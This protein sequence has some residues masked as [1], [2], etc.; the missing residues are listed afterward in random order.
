MAEELLGQAANNP[1][2]RR[3]RR[4]A[5]PGGLRSV[6]SSNADGGLLPL[7][8]WPV[9]SPATGC[10]DCSLDNSRT[11]AV[12]ASYSGTRASQPP[13]L[14]SARRMR[15][16]TPSDWPSSSP[17]D[18]W[19]AA[20]P[21]PPLAP[22]KG[23]LVYELDASAIRFLP[24]LGEET[25]KA[26]SPCWPPC[27]GARSPCVP[28]MPVIGVAPCQW[29]CRRPLAGSSGAMAAMTAG[30]SVCSSSLLRTQWHVVVSI[31]WTSFHSPTDTLCPSC[32][33]TMHG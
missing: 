15:A 1:P 8:R 18:D 7:A 11:P 10:S 9:P 32:R 20:H 4:P 29:P 5:A 14:S 28:L 2:G 17:L 23:H 22:S 21:Q 3:A 12:R 19:T 30:N 13:M 6:T 27:R 31:R 24:L 33:P 25:V 26:E 16:C